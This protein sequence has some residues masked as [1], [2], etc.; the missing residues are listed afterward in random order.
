MLRIVAVTPDGIR[1]AV[2]AMLDE[3]HDTHSTTRERLRRAISVGKLRGDS[4]G[5]A[6]QLHELHEVLPSATTEEALCRISALYAYREPVS[7]NPPLIA[8]A[9]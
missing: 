5:G 7:G 6:L 3:A 1:F 2:P 4:G 8:D 9:P